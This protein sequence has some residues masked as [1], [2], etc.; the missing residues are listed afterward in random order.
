MKLK[1][2][3]KDL[4]GKKVT[5]IIGSTKITDAVISFDGSHYGIMQNKI[6]GYDFPKSF[7]FGYKCSW[8][9]EGIGQNS[10]RDLCLVDETPTYEIY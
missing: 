4:I 10:V 8:A 1:K 6:Q 5:C 9:I 3:T 7:K 2:L